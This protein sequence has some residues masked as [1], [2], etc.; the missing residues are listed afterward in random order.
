MPHILTIQTPGRALIEITDEIA[1]LTLACPAHSG[2]AHIFI[3]HTSASLVI[4]ENADPDVRQDLI[5]YFD[6][7]APES[8]PYIHTAEGSDDMPAHVKSALTATSLAIPFVDG[9]LQLGAWQ[10]VY[11]FEHRRAP[12]QRRILVTFIAEA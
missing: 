8:G 3:Q 4:Q 9:R 5:V 12:H 7:V 10:G 11:V 1:A 2:I 6:R